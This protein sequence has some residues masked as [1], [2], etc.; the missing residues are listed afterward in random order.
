MRKLIT[1]VVLAGIC[2]FCACGPNKAEKDA[3]DKA[4]KD[5]ID[6]YKAQRDAE[7][8]DRKKEKAD[9]TAAYETA[10]AARSQAIADSTARAEAGKKEKPAKSKTTLKKETAP[11]DKPVEQPKRTRSGKNS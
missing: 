10:Q 1:S 8:A 6:A 5:S 11:A 7:E 3:A 4:R 2:L 9:S